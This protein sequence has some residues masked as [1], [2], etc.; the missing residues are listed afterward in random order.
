MTVIARP[1]RFAAVVAGW[2]AALSPTPARAED[3]DECIQ[4]SEQAVAQR[5][6]GHLLEARTELSACAASRCP[7]VVRRSCQE[8]L[9]EVRRGVPSVVF[10]VK[11]ASGQD[12]SNVTVFV[13]DAAKGQHLGGAVQLDPGDHAFRFVTETG[14]EAR[15][16]LFL[17]EGEQE[18]RETVTVRPGEASNESVRGTAAPTHGG[19]IADA[20]AA[21]R[22]ATQR[23]GG[24]GSV[25]T[26]AL[27]GAGVGLAGL[28]AGGI[29][30]ALSLAAHQS[31]EQH[32]GSRVGYPPGVCDSIGYSGHSDAV[33]KGDLS[34]WFFVG[35]GVLTAAGLTVALF[36]G[37]GGPTVGVAPGLVTIRGTF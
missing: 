10:A 30:G 31:Y 9:A 2:V 4:A 7:E 15:I 34:T 13:D 3:A 18:R 12:A 6:Q 25:R 35:G 11:D 17:R 24:G 14:A 26:I 36:A 33:L 37:P 27:I 16:H 22:P 28:A 5:K 29:F 23:S 20:R 8:R 21:P 1:L 32:C 19:A